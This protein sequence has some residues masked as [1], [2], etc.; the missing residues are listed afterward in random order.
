MLGDDSHK[1]LPIPESRSGYKRGNL[2]MAILFYLCDGDL[3]KT[4]SIMKELLCVC[5][6]ILPITQDKALIQG[7]TDQ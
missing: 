2:L 4:M 7:I 1:S 5:D 3:Q 6:D